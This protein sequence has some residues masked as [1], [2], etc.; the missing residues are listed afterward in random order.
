MLP[1]LLKRL[2]PQLV[3]VVLLV[4]LVR[5]RRRRSREG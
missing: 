4:W 3:A 2:A 1:I 5:R